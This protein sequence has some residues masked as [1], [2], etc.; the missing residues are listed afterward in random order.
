MDIREEHM[1][2]RCYFISA[3]CGLSLYNWLN[4]SL[5]DPINTEFFTPYNQNGVLFLFYLTWDTYHMINNRLLYR[6]DLL[7][8][9]GA[10]FIITANSINH[11]GLQMSHYMILECIS[12]MNY[13]WRHN[14][15][16][17]NAY[18]TA[19]ILLIRL[20]LTFWFWLYYNP[21]FLYPRWIETDCSMNIII[22]KAMCF[23]IVYDIYILW[24]IYK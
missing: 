9:H 17:L 15:Q 14:P 20:P 10:A 18:R 21:T 1:K 12:L 16:L 6:T 4:Y 3:M 22:S 11:N 5:F 24:K 2:H 13:V 8:H 7:I 23:F 19:C